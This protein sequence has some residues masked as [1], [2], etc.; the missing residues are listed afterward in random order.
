MR[1]PL[2]CS[3]M[4]RSSFGDSATRMSSASAWRGLPQ[5]PGAWHRRTAVGCRFDVPQVCPAVAGS[6]HHAPARVCEA[7]VHADRKPV[8]TV[9]CLQDGAVLGIQHKEAAQVRADDELIAGGADDDAEE[10]FVAGF[11]TAA[12]APLRQVPKAQ[13]SVAP[14]ANQALPLRRDD[15]LIQ[16]IG[17]ARGAP[18][19]G[20]RRELERPDAT[21]GADGNQLRRLVQRHALHAHAHA[22]RIDDAGRQVG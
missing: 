20:E 9:E 4:S 8:R 7:Y 5:D 6:R 17:K 22:L 19:F 10:G 14:G 1:M 11:P 21:A 3:T 16:L 15:Q 12:H 13:A 18:S 2:S